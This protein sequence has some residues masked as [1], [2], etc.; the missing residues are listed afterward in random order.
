MCRRQ[1]AGSPV[2]AIVRATERFGI[3]GV[4][5][6]VD[7]LTSVGRPAGNARAVDD[8]QI[9][10]ERGRDG[11]AHVCAGCEH[12]VSER[13][14]D[15]GVAWPAAM[16]PD[17]RTG[18]RS[19]T[20]TDGDGDTG[21]I[22]GVRGIIEGGYTPQPEAVV[23]GTRYEDHRLNAPQAVRSGGPFERRYGTAVVDDP[24][25]GGTER[26]VIVQLET[27][28][29]V[30]ERPR[31]DLVV[32]LDV[33]G[34]M[35]E[36]VEGHRNGGVA[37]PSEITKLAVAIRGVCALAGQ[38]CENDRLAIV[39]CG[40]QATVAKPL[41]EVASTDLAAIRRQIRRVDC[42][43]DTDLADGVETAVGLLEHDTDSRS[44]QRLFLISDVMPNTGS[45]G[46]N[47]L[48]R[49]FADAAADGVHTTLVG[50]GPDTDAGLASILSGVRGA[51]HRVVCSGE[52]F[53]RLAT[54]L[55]DGIGRLDASA[56]E[57]EAALLEC[58]SAASDDRNG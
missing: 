54:A 55:R 32:V 9:P 34:S 22:R 47:E 12:H 39:L 31:L 48:T 43:G 15:T 52:R 1:T 33:S 35:R 46:R 16:A 21:S 5:G 53:G 41:R 45:T 37:D 56:L 50:V 23:G 58:L 42:G 28:P 7:G 3:D 25:D 8:W 30:F 11:R 20:D 17:R 57:T 40:R 19:R 27:R 13:K 36:P 38:L 18:R 6:I 49:V 4:F 29:D 44:E 51:N 24:L 26:Y 2:A 10:T 14:R